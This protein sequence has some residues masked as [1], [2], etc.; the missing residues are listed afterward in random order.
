MA[1]SELRLRYPSG[2]VEQAAVYVTLESLAEDT[3][4]G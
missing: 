4:M 1:L 3:K 2:E